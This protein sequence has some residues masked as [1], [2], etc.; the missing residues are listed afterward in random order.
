M[1]FLRV[2]CGVSKMARAE[3]GAMVVTSLERAMERAG[4]AEGEA[5]MTPMTLMSASFLLMLAVVV[6]ML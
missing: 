3:G 6:M 2:S 1:F 4:S 5:S